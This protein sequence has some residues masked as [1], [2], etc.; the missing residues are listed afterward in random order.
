MPPPI[1]LLVGPRP[2]LLRKAR[3][4]GLRAVAIHT[5]A[6]FLPAHASLVEAALLVDYTDWCVLR[7]LVVAAHDVFRF[8]AVVS[9]LEPGL[10]PAG[11]IA[12]LLGL[13][14]NSHAVSNRLRD[15][16][17][18]REHLAVSG[19]AGLAA[20]PVTDAAALAAFARRHGFPVIVKPADASASLGVMRADGP[21]DLD[22]VWATAD[23]L[24]GSREHEF[25][26]FFPIDRFIVEQYVDGPEYSVEAL[27]FDG[28][29]VVVA[30]T[31]KLTLPGFVE[32]GHALPARL[33]PEAERA[34]VDSVT[35]FLDVMGVQHG[36]THTE[37]KVAAGDVHV[38]ESHTRTG[39]DRIVDLVKH[40]FAIDLEAYAVAWAAGLWPALR[41]R[42]RPRAAA[43]TR[44]LVAE[45]GEVIDV[46]G[47]ADART[48]PG[49]VEVSVGVSKGQT[50]RPL[51]ASWDRIGQVIATAPITD[52]AI[53]CCEQAASRVRVLTEP[54]RSATEPDV[55]ARRALRSI[56]Q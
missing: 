44:F 25:A 33:H 39:G 14:G 6:T 28:R 32:L 49:V 29:H 47:V 56:G 45:P 15:K 12:D 20:A 53:T 9:N 48:V 34:V 24:R 13:R 30:V 54:R 3:D 36:P 31:E 43:A 5:P 27:S 51:R 8:A 50:V 23:R 42:P 52:A 37:V 38:I 46:S 21:C 10:E 1:V 55:S 4:L 17:A 7:P 18:M 2:E 16:W 41:D 22:R 40:A 19:A 35:A 26:E 11:R